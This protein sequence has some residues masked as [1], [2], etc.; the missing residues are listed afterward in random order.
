[1]QSWP[2]WLWDWTKGELI[3]VALAIV[4]VFILYAVIR[5]SPRRWWLYFWLATLPILFTSCF[6]NPL[7]VEPMFYHFEPLAAQHPALVEQLEKLV[8]RGGLAIPP[9]RMFEMKCQREAEI[10]E[11]VRDRHRRVQA[12]SGLGHHARHD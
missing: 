4:L 2:S 8:A 12:R 1:M 9:D 5:R 7:V 11:R 6:W 3:G 10:P